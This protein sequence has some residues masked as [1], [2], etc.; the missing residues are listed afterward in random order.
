VFVRWCLLRILEALKEDYC[1]VFFIRQNARQ[2]MCEMTH[3]ACQRGFALCIE[4]VWSATSSQP[5]V[6]ALRV[7]SNLARAGSWN[8]PVSFSLVA[9]SWTRWRIVVDAPRRPAL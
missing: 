9:M 2:M 7:S 6:I 3:L 5:W 8:D 1:D 4:G